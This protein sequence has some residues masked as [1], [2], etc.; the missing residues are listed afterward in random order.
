MWQEYTRL[1]PDATP[2]WM[3][4]GLAL[5]QVDR[6]TDARDV[7][8]SVVQR[9]PGNPAAHVNLAYAL[10]NT[11][12]YG[13]SLK[14]FRVALGLEKDPAGRA[15]IEQAIATLLGTH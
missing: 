5:V 6:D 7:F 15:E 12:R 2:A 4:L 11:N 14:E 13:D 3:N 10:A 9:E 1:K 8:A